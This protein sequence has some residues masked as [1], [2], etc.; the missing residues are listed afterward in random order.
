MSTSTS[1]R[2]GAT[3]ANIRLLYKLPGRRD[4]GVAAKAAPG[5]N[6][7]HPEPAKGPPAIRRRG[8]SMPTI[9]IEP[10]LGFS[11]EAIRQH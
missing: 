11:A 1:Y 9:T 8:E 10:G 7:V 5:E 2:I 6:V 3:V 4:G